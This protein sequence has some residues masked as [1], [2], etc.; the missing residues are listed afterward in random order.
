M[1][2]LSQK[3]FLSCKF[4]QIETV[5]YSSLHPTNYLARGRFSSCVSATSV[6]GTPR[7]SSLQIHWKLH[8]STIPIH[9]YSLLSVRWKR[10]LIQ[11]GGGH[12]SI[13]LVGSWITGIHSVPSSSTWWRGPENLQT[14]HLRQLKQAESQVGG[15]GSR[16]SIQGLELRSW[17]P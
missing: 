17:A 4:S 10:I 5:P 11:E 3:N 16:I 2:S 9:T 12:Q 15:E 8:S 13:S 6:L 7:I 14:R 1:W